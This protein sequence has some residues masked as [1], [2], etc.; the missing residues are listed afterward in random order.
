[1]SSHL[2]SELRTRFAET[3]ITPDLVHDFQT[4][5]MEFY[6]TNGRHDL[7]WRLWFDPYRIVV[8]EVMLQQTQ[9]PRVAMTF[10]TFIEKFPDFAALSVAPQAKLLSAWQGL[11]YNRRVLNLK[12]FAVKIIEEFDGVLPNDPRV[13]ATFP[14]I[15]PATSCSIAAFVFNR[16]VVFIETNIRRV[17]IHHFFSDTTVVDDRDII[18]LVDACFLPNRSRE[19]YWALMDL[20]AAL[21]TFVPNPNR[22]SRHYVKQSMF[23]GSDRQIRGVL[24]R[25]MLSGITADSTLLSNIVGFEPDRVTGI[26]AEMCREGFFVQEESGEYRIVQ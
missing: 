6:K 9:V 7:E 19:W 15:G 25:L 2:I 8:S 14:G 3:G 21:K 20:G 22:R 23:E 26:L 18:P 12:K 4:E 13:L 10:P 24:L 17:F 11:G 16:P 1:M 5:V